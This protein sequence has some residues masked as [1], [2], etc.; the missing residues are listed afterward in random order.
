MVRRV[1]RL[2]EGCGRSGVGWMRGLARPLDFI[3]MYGPIKTFG[4]YLAQV[5]EQLLL[6]GVLIPHHLS[7][8]DPTRFSRGTNARRQLDCIPKQIAVLLNG[9]TGTDTNP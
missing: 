6:P 7:D 9:F 5:G 8:S 2:S 3:H 4:R 1:D